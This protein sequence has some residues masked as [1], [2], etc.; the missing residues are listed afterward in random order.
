M[1]V[2]DVADILEDARENEKQVKIIL[3]GGGVIGLYFDMK[4]D[5]RYSWIVDEDNRIYI[6]QHNHNWFKVEE[7]NI[8][9]CYITYIH[10]SR[11]MVKDGS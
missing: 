6:K 1:N 11:E 7:Y 9:C 10:C 2:N 3:L 8:E 5:Y 4:E